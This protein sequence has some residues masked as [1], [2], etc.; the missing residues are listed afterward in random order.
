MTDDRRQSLGLFGGVSQAVAI[1]PP[2]QKTEEEFNSEL[3][4][5]APKGALNAAQK[6]RAWHPAVM[7]PPAPQVPAGGQSRLRD[8]S[9]A[10]RPQL[11]S[12][13]SSSGGLYFI[14]PSA[15]ESDYNDGLAEQFA[16]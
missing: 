13:V 10:R 9:K 14:Q 1:A 4:E 3:H 16:G 11:G 2:G 7:A 15:S 8:L 6:E 12:S 5:E